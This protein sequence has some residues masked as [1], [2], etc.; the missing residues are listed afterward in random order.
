MNRHLASALSLIA[1]LGVGWPACGGETG[2][3]VRVMAANITSGR[4]PRYEAS[5]HPIFRV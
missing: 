2:V 4:H 5:R 3:A 1:A